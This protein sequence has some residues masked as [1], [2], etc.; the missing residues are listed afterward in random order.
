MD[1]YSLERARPRRPSAGLAPTVGIAR[2]ARH[3]NTTTAHRASAPTIVK[4][5]SWLMNQ[6]ITSH[7]DLGIVIQCLAFMMRTIS[8]A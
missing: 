6:E 7:D 2:D 3:V 1:L 5:A 8:S 4:T